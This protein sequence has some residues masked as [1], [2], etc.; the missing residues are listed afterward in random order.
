VEKTETTLLNTEELLEKIKDKKL[1]DYSEQVKK[2][3][4]DRDNVNCSKLIENVG[5]DTFFSMDRTGMCNLVENIKDY[6]PFTGLE[7]C[8]QQAVKEAKYCYNVFEGGDSPFYTL[9]KKEGSCWTSDCTCN[10]ITNAKCSDIYDNLQKLFP[11]CCWNDESLRE[12]GVSSVKEVCKFFY[13][14]I[15]ACCKI[16]SQGDEDFWVKIERF[17]Q[18]VKLCKEPF[19]YPLWQMFVESLR[20]EFADEKERLGVFYYE[21]LKNQLKNIKTLWENRD[22]CPFK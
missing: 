22:R 15:G 16:L 1:I 4:E 7:K 18:N 20:N 2:F 17:Q 10:R 3:C 5:A 6:C 12:N 9:S 19:D 13:E 14:K 8:P 21:L 11:T